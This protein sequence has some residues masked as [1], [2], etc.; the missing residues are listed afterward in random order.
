M[1]EAQYIKKPCCHSCS[2]DNFLKLPICFLQL[3]N[4]LIM[5]CFEKVAFFNPPRQ[6]AVVTSDGS[7]IT[8]SPKTRQVAFKMQAKYLRAT[9]FGRD[10]SEGNYEYHSSLDIPVLVIVGEQDKLCSVDDVAVMDAVL[11][12]SSL[13]VIPKAGHMLMLDAPTEL[14]NQILHFIQNPPPPFYARKEPRLIPILE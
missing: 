12:R 2:Y 8:K 11:P 4:P 6:A 7:V 1:D 5:C 3:V 9:I 14:N 13:R 10:W